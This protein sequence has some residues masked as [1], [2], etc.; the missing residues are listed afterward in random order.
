VA[1]ITAPLVD[2]DRFTFAVL[3]GVPRDPD[4][5]TKVADEAARLMQ[6]T[7]ERLYGAPFYAEVYTPKRTKAKKKGSAA[8]ASIPTSQMPPRRGPHR[9]ETVGLGMGGG[10]EEPTPFFHFALNR[11][12]LANLLAQEPF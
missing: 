9:A 10:Q 7:A 4:W 6:E 3:I 5:K 11:I 2:E 1:R 12:L 8:P